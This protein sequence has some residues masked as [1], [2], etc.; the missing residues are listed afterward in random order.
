MSAARWRRAMNVR[1]GAAGAALRPV[2]ATP[3]RV[4]ASQPA[5]AAPHGFDVLRR[6]IG[7]HHVVVLAALAIL[8]FVASPF[9]T[10]QV[11]AQS[12]VLGLIALSLTFLAGYGGMVSLAQMTV[13]GIS[14]Y[15]LAV[16]GTSSSA[17]ISLGWPWWAAVPFALL[18]ATLAATL[19]GWLSVRTEGIYTIMITLAIGVAFYYLVLQ[20][21]SLFNGFQGLRELKPPT[22]LGIAWRDPVPFYFLALAW[23]LGGYLLVRWV[24][25]TPFGI[26]LQGI[27]DNPRRMRALGFHVVA[28]R[29]AA[30]ALAGAIAAVGGILLAWY[31]ALMSPGSV[32]TSWLINILVIAVLGG[33]RHPIG[34]FLGALVFV[35]L[36]TFAIDLIDRERFNLVIGGVFLAIVLFSPDGLLGLWAMLR[37]RF[38]PRTGLIS[39]QRRQP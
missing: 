10:Y 30:Y 29:V 4:G 8:P 23:S 2:P 12:L 24:V 35:L 39:N 21:Y 15:A 13:A 31:N 26:A 33:M 37:A 7:A 20:N 25:R 6:R 19:I 18:I 11:A 1:G 3:A 9:L 5:V 34:A 22:V 16:L 38:G 17:D 32:G 28:H 36:Q 27:R 14:G